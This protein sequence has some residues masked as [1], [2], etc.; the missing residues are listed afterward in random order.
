MSLEQWY[1]VGKRR[2]I[3]VSFLCE[4]LSRNE[5]D[6]FIYYFIYFLPSRNMTF[7]Q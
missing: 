1:C 2:Q 3:L 4:T 7:N 5:I 6:V